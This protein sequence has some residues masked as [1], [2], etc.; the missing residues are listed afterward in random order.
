MRRSLLSMLLLALG[1]LALLY[2]AA[3]G[4]HAQN[5]NVQT[6][7]EPAAP[8]DGLWRFHTGDDPTWADPSFDDSHWPLLRSASPLCKLRKGTIRKSEQSALHSKKLA[9]ARKANGAET[10]RQYRHKT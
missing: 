2:C 3:P 10:Q 6:A 8:L 7:S 9:R 5:F 1:S 4:L